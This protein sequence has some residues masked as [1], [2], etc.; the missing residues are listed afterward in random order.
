REYWDF[1]EKRR[2]LLVPQDVRERKGSFFTPQIWVELSQKYLAD[3]FGENWQEEYYVWDCCAG[4]G[5]LLAGLTNKYNI[6][7]STLDEADVDVMR[8]R[9]ENGANLL[10][11]HVFQFDFLNDDFSK[12]PQG[13]QDIINDEKRRKKLIIYINPPCAESGIYGKRSKAGVATSHKINEKYKSKIGA[14]ANDI[15]IQFLIRIYM[16]ITGSILATFGTLKYV[17]APNSTLFR[18]VFQPE[19]KKGFICNCNTFDNVNGKFPYSFLIWNSAKKKEIKNVV[20]NVFADNG[21]NVGV[22]SFYSTKKEVITDWYSQFY[23]Y[24]DESIGILR[25]HGGADFQTNRVLHIATIDIKNH[26][27]KITLQNLTETCIYF[28][29]RKVIPVTWLNNRD[30]FYF[31][32]KKWEKDTEF[33]NDCLAYTLFHSQNRISAK[34][35]VNH[36]IP[37]MEK[38]VNAKDKFES[39]FMVSFISGKII[40]NG[41]SDLFEQEEAKFCLK[42]EFS[43]EA[44]AVFDAGLEL[45]KYYHKTIGA[46]DEV[47]ASLYD[48][49]EYFKGRNEKGS[50]NQKSADKEFNRLNENLNFSMKNLAQKIEPKIY[51]Y[52]FL[53]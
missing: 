5:N 30:Q 24:K 51:E 10:D 41:Y 36:W 35:G 21:V 50:V 15:Y 29:V 3:V 39:H 7:A 1:I 4:T 9:I 52:E 45:W 25:Q 33:Q 34:H 46:G 28:A 26:T 22:K 16:E 43:P 11:K 32:N 38:E 40:Q 14:A 49:K 42:R 20:C 8:D 17:N 2:D 53:K 31:P 19:Y 37:F 23:D 47:N 27:N 12:L 13:L 18:E 48:I 6:W 44:T